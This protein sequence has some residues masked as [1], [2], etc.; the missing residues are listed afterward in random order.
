[1]N[2]LNLLSK[3]RE[4]FKLLIAN[5]INRFGDAIDVVAYMWLVYELTNSASWSAFI[6]AVNK[7]PN[8]ILQPILGSWIEKK[9]KKRIMVLV[10]IIR[11]CLVMLLI[12]FYFSKLLTIQLLLGLTCITSV[13]ECFRIPAGM[14]FF[15]EVLDK[16]DY[17][18]GMALNTAGNTLAELIGYFAT[19]IIISKCGCIIAIAVDGVTFYLSALLIY[20]IK[21]KADIVKVGHNHGIIIEFKEGLTLIRSSTVIKNFIL[22]AMFAN[23]ILTPINTFIVPYVKEYMGGSSNVVSSLNISIAIGVFLGAIVTPRIMEKIGV[24]YSIILAGL[25]IA[26]SFVVL[27]MMPT[28]CINKL[29]IITTVLVTGI[30]GIG[31]GIINT[32][33]KTQLVT[34]VKN[35]YMSRVSAVFNG[36][37]SAILPISAW[38]F[39][40]I[41]RIIIFTFMH[42]IIEI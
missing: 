34:I 38:I 2:K 40:F 4:F 20:C 8:V 23:A 27:A 31:I 5:T 28:I 18:N 17:K 26:I 36:C 13:V 22:M 30:Y 25:L 9:E 33:L 6:Y 37:I 11:G 15:Q 19:G 39:G 10:D 24:D 14:A 41:V 12:F 42:I 1:M 7:I 32:S 35:D 21:V 16:Q 29:A 3:E